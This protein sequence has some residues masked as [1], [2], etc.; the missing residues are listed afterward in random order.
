MAKNPK[1]EAVKASRKAGGFKSTSVYLSEVDR[2]RW[3]RLA[4]QRGMAKTELLVAAFDALEARGEPTAEEALRVITR[5][6]KRS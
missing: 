6:V 2:G 4:K 5:L 1:S 3:A